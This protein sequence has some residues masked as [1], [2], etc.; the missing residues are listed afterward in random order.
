MQI[1]A[2]DGREADVQ[3]FTELIARPDVD[4]STRRRIE[5]ELRQV[6][7][8]ARGEREAAYEIE[9]HLRENPNRMTIHDLRLEVDGRVAQIDHLILDRL[10]GIWVC[11]SKH[12]SEGVA[13]N[14]F[15]E[16][17]GFFRSRP[18]G[19]GSPIEQNRKH[20]AVV[21]DLFAKRLVELPKRLGFTLKP[22]LRSLILVSKEA[23]ITRPKTKAARARIEGLDSVIKIDQLSQALKAEIEGRA[24]RQGLKV[25]GAVTLERLARQ[26][27]AL[28]KPATF[29]WPAR[30]GLSARPTPA[31]P[32]PARAPLSAPSPAATCA[33]CGK[34]VSQ[35]V[36]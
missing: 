16:W 22:D 6:Q 17:T 8:G 13:V 34:H 30:F 32:V 3:A 33:G 7:A 29:D 23:R 15:G 24:L 1:K 12:F 36:M 20:I 21:G 31:N 4:A 18:Y 10:L 27:A 14:D 5:T 11:E 25:V 28:H 35:E 26:L 19:I 9:F 2:A